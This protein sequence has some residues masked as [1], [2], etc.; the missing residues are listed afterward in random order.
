MTTIA[1]G[2]PRLTDDAAMCTDVVMR[3]GE[4]PVVPVLSWQT[5]RA[6]VANLILDAFEQHKYSRFAWNISEPG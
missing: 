3:Q 4:T 2:P 5:S 1:T 6:T